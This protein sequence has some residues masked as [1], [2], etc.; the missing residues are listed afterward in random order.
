MVLPRLPAWEQQLFTTPTNGMHVESHKVWMIMRSFMVR[1]TSESTVTRPFLGPPHLQVTWSTVWM[2]VRVR[3]QLV[4]DHRCVW[5]W[6]KRWES[7]ES[8]DFAGIGK[9]P[10]EKTHGIPI[11]QR[12]WKPSSEDIRSYS[13][14]S[15]IG[16]RYRPDI[17]QKAI[18]VLYRIASKISDINTD[19][20]GPFCCSASAL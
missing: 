2:W 8:F 4:L 20:N 15:N 1:V 9:T 13:G 17:S 6:K 12:G 19:K 3:A 16:I 14:W 5:W 11:C 18:I 7:T 10:V